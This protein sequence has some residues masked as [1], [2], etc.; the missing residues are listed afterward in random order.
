MSDS[1]TPNRPN[2]L[3]SG[4]EKANSNE[5]HSVSPLEPLDPYRLRD[6]VVDRQA[7]GSHSL[8]GSWSSPSQQPL[9]INSSPANNRTPGSNVQSPMSVQPQ[10][11]STAFSD[12]P[13]ASTP[14]SGSIINPQMQQQQQNSPFAVPMGY[15]PQQQQ[16]EMAYAASPASQ[17]MATPHSV[18]MIGQSPLGSPPQQPISHPTPQ[19]PFAMPPRAPS[20]ASSTA[21][22]PFPMVQPQ[23]VLHHPMNVQQGQYP[24]GAFPTGQSPMYGQMM[25]AQQQQ[26][27]MVYPGMQPMPGQMHHYPYQQP[28]WV[29]Q[30]NQAQHYMVGQQQH[31]R[32]MGPPPSGQMKPGMQPGMPVRVPYPGQGY[33]YQSQMMYSQPG[34]VGPPPPSAVLPAQ[35]PGPSSAGP[36]GTSQ[37]NSGSTPKQKGSKGAQQAAAAAA[38]AQQQQAQFQRQQQVQI[39]QGFPPGTVV[40]M[41]GH[42]NQQGQ[43]TSA[44]YPGGNGSQ[45]MVGSHPAQQPQYGQPQQMR[46]APTA[47]PNP[48]E[49]Q[50]IPP[51]LQLDNNNHSSS[52]LLCSNH[53]PQ[54]FNLPLTVDFWI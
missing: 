21:A 5:G 26:Q 51:Q 1:S 44:M 18:G 24:P 53:P 9:P 22:S 29:H 16:Q 19:S 33:P 17:R 46:L 6:M 4:N 32:L 42:P 8:Q 37:S 47:N 15:N 43:Y 13:A 40:Q 31:Q 20:T 23:Q 3:T 45:G 54:L 36:A 38:L 30:Q 49:Q 50:A 39:A 25:A 27:R 12:H 34:S 48:S 10:R 28:Q 52:H 35:P 14:L 41:G 11:S 2:I 7:N